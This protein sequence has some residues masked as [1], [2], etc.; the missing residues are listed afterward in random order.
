MIEAVATGVDP[1]LRWRDAYAVGAVVASSGY[2]QACRNGLFV[3]ELCEMKHGYLI[4]AG[5]TLNGHSQLVSNGGR[6]LLVGSV[7]KSLMEANEKVY[8]YLK[9]IEKTDNFFYRTDIGVV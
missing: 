2:P 1:K 7:Q 3:P 4:H 8:Q 5:T 6:V 9:T